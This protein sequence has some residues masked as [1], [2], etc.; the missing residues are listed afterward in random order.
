VL[1][2]GDQEVLLAR[3]AEQWRRDK[4]SSHLAQNS[5]EANLTPLEVAPIQI[6]ELDVKLLVDEKSQ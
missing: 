3:Y 4:H 5:D 2:T 6:A 1:V